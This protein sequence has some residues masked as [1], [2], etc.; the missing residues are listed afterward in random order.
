MKYFLMLAG[1]G[2]MAPW[3]E[4]S[5]DEQEVQMARHEAFG[6]ACAARP[7]V[8]IL[9]GEALGGGA[10]RADGLHPSTDPNRHLR[11]VSRGPRRRRDSISAACWSGSDRRNGC[12]RRRCHVSPSRSASH[13]DWNCRSAS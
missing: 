11:R 9:G 3:D 2:E 5:P 1:Y 10:H 8:E 13:A 6:E 4:L 12:C 7:G